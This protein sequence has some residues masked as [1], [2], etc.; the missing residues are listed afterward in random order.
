[1]KPERQLNTNI[2]SIKK[3][4]CDISCNK[5]KI[6]PQRSVP[7]TVQGGRNGSGELQ[8][9]IIW[10][11]A[12]AEPGLFS[13]VYATIP[14]FNS[15]GFFVSKDKMSLP[16]AAEET[17]VQRRY[18]SLKLK[19]MSKTLTQDA[20]PT[21][22]APPVPS[23]EKASDH[24]YSLVKWDDLP[25]WR[26]D[27]HYIQGYYRRD[28]GSILRSF[29][30]L[31]YW[32]NETINIYSHLIPALLSLP[33]AVAIY[34]LLEPRHEQATKSDV[35]AFCCFF[36]G[37]A[38]CL[39]MS[40]TYHTISN[41][42]P[43][44]NQIGNQLD[45][46]GIVLLITGSFV[47]CVYYGFWCAPTLQKVYWAMVS[48][49]ESLIWFALLRCVTDIFSRRCLHNRVRLATIS[50]TRMEAVSSVYV[51]SIGTFS[52]LPSLT[53][54]QAVRFPADVSA[55]G[56]LVGGVARGTIHH[57][58]GTLC[59]KYRPRPRYDRKTVADRGRPGFLK[60]G[61][62]EDTMLLEARIRSFTFLWYSP[63]Y[64]I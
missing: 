25:H 51:C 49:P 56:P 4:P 19:T 52:R 53:R 38:L 50:D 13:P 32:H 43:M 63:P 62:R 11:R 1:M 17:F 16:S 45:Y 20:T 26:Q 8:V 3:K 23:A 41:H 39:G 36:L 9:V 33:C 47:P 54:A 35:I 21:V 59:C 22:S 7:H 58:S 2:E 61:I 12:R 44:V 42:S 55:D 10:M 27:N 31:A 48:G 46:V 24:W 14:A 60:S 15:S 34:E 37:A 57:W 30:S 64:H 40:A 29:G 28:S 6:C 18:I 5:L